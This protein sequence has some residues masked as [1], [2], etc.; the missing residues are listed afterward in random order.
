LLILLKCNRDHIYGLNS[1]TINMSK[2]L[3]YTTY[4]SIFIAYINLTRIGP[5]LLGISQVDVLY[6]RQVEYN[7]QLR[8]KN[9]FSHPCM[10]PSALLWESILQPLVLLAMKLLSFDSKKALCNYC[11]S[12]SLSNWQW[13]EQPCPS[14]A[15]E[16]SGLGPELLRKNQST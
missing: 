13:T 8:V 15:W 6:K 14:Q 2:D 3:K 11:D 5:P 4:S 1:L 9:P 16:R 7:R 10:A 12:V